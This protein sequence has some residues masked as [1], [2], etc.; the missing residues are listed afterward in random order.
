VEEDEDA[1]IQADGLGSHGRGPKSSKSSQH[2]GTAKK[3]GLSDH[4]YYIGSAKQASDFMVITEFLI[5]YIRQKFDQG[6]DIDNA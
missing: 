6:S 1:I 2:D 4:I 5:N 3:K